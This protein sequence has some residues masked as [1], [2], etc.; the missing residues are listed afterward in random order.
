[1]QTQ[2]GPRQ[3]SPY[4]IQM[5]RSV[6]NKDSQISDGTATSPEWRWGL[7][8]NC[9]M[10][11]KSMLFNTSPDSVM[12]ERGVESVVSLVK[13]AER[14]GPRMEYREVQ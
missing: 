3:T 14:Q 10:F 2:K 6:F 12:S 4:L 13:S 7:Y 9:N 11:L 5:F 1:M 8:G